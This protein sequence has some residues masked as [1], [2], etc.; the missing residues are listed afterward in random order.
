MTLEIYGF[1]VSQPVRSVVMFCK[2]NQIP[3]E[4]H[5]ID[6]LKGEQ[7]SESFKKINP[8]ET[9]PC[10]V[11][12]GYTLWESAAIITYLADAFDIDSQWYPKD[13]QKRGK[14]NAYLHRH[15][16]DIRFIC[17][18]LPY[19]TVICKYVYGIEPVGN[20]AKL[21]LEE[22]LRVFL[23][24][25][26]KTVQS[27]FVCGADLTIADIFAFNEI[28]QNLMVDFDYMVFPN[29]AD[30]VRTLMAIPEVESEL[31]GLLAFKE[32]LKQNP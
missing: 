19:Y 15:H 12:N 30:W 9:V 21:Q 3:Y 32:H 27:R 22:N 18:Q 2:L 10:I 31:S 29:I 14:I 4:F 7:K 26:D 16:E 24:E 28:V 1:M 11:H 17:R 20:E 13:I 5:E 25:F 6:L 8:Y 23:T